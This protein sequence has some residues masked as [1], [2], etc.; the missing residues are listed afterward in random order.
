MDE[1]EEE[2]EKEERIRGRRRCSLNAEKE[3]FDLSKRQ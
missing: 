3:P 2:E 1:E